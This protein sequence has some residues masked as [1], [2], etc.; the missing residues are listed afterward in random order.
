LGPGAGQ[1]AARALWRH[2]GRFLQWLSRAIV[3][4]TD[5]MSSVNRVVLLGQISKFGVTVKYAQS[6]T[7][8][9][10]FALMLSEQRQGSKPHAIFVD[11]DVWGKKA[12]SAGELAA[13]QL[14]VFEGRLARRKATQIEEHILQHTNKQGQW[15][16]GKGWQAETRT[17]AEGRGG[18]A[19]AAAR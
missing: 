5:R 9:A 15:C 3:E 19:G 18:A 13:G 14:C 4:G 8:C 6:G 7:P 10:T 1:H 16:G 12:E 11:C 2:C 17:S